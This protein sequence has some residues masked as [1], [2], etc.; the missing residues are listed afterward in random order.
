[1]EARDEL[2]ATVADNVRA[3]LDGETPANYI[4]PE[5]EWL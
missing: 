4:D 1:V 5:T 3:A 2:N